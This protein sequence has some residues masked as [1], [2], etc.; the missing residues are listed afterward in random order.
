MRFRNLLWKI[1]DISYHGDKP[2]MVRLP[3][4]GACRSGPTVK[5]VF[6]G[7]PINESGAQ[8]AR[9]VNHAAL[10]TQAFRMAFH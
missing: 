9:F 6:A 2:R 4:S 3:L 7:N 10:R 1:G 8:G 5:K